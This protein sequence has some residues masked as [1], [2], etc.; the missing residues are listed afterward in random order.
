M[1]REPAGLSQLSESPLHIYLEEVGRHDIQLKTDPFP[2]VGPYDYESALILALPR[3]HPRWFPT[4]KA[5]P[6]SCLWSKTRQGRDLCGRKGP[7]Y[8][9]SHYCVVHVSLCSSA[10][11]LFCLICPACQFML[12]V[13]VVRSDRAGDFMIRHR[14]DKWMNGLLSTQLHVS[15]VCRLKDNSQ[16]WPRCT[17]IPTSDCLLLLG[18]LSDICPR[19]ISFH[20]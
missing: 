1:V 16:R 6:V 7:A 5:F 11:S 13:K 15:V 4:G 9:L 10:L 12:C 20:N 14:S 2:R 17:I 19:D 18:G 3:T 8:P